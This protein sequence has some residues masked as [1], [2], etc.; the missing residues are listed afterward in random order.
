MIPRA[1]M[2][3]VALASL[4]ITGAYFYATK[5]E[6]IPQDVPWYVMI[7]ML[8]FVVCSVLG[9]LSFCTPN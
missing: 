9:L 2:G 3:I 5:D 4:V 8:L 6:E 1:T 7:A